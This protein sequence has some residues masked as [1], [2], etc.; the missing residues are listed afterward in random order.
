MF[1]LIQH[2]RLLKN[3]YY[4][5]V[6]CDRNP[7]WH[8]FEGKMTSQCRARPGIKSGVDTSELTKKASFIEKSQSRDTE[9][10]FSML[11]LLLSLF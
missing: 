1:V 6:V 8:K 5:T 11:L 10:G 3:N 9:P 7:V 4:L 2:E